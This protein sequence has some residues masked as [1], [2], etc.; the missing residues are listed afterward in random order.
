MASFWCFIQLSLDG[1]I[2]WDFNSSI[3]FSV[4]PTMS[5][6][7]CFNLEKKIHFSNIRWLPICYMALNMLIPA[8]M[9]SAIWNISFSTRLCFPNASIKCLALSSI[10]TVK[11]IQIMK[12][13]ID[14]FWEKNSFTYISRKSLLC[15]I[16][17]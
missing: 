17:R 6:C 8:A 1:D 7:N 3:Y 4:L 11:Q 9:V 15:V 16:N 14:S 2:I 10:Y 13:Y 5:K 12:H